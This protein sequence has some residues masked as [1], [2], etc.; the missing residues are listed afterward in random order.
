MKDKVW[1]Q[2][3]YRVLLQLVLFEIFSCFP[4]FKEIK[5]K[6]VEKSLT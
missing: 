6:S 2:E 4:T 3:H 5:V 1:P